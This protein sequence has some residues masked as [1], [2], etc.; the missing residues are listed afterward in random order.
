MRSSPSRYDVSIQF[1]R[2][3]FNRVSDDGKKSVPKDIHKGMKTMRKGLVK[4]NNQYLEKTRTLADSRFKI[5]PY[6]LNKDLSIKDEQPEW[7]WTHGIEMANKMTS[8]GKE[9]YFRQ[10]TIRSFSRFS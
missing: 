1:S 10:E 2:L 4:L 6:I 9:Y 8:Q 7:K 5:T 3:F